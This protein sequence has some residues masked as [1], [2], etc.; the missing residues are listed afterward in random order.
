MTYL[1]AWSIRPPLQPSLPSNL[2]HSTKFCSLSD[3]ILPLFLNCWPSRAPVALKAQQEPHW[4]WGEQTGHDDG[5]EMKA[6]NVSFVAVNFC[7]NLRAKAEGTNRTTE[8]K[9]IHPPA[10]PWPVYNELAPP[11]WQHRVKNV[12]RGAERTG[13]ALMEG[14]RR[15]IG[16][17]AV[18]R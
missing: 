14:G 5:E 6:H 17:S 10:A 13:C 12:C 8:K 9:R 18:N 7:I 11:V 16:V 4:P 2:E 3:T 1:K 15:G